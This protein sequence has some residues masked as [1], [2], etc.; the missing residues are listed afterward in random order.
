MGR[1][2]RL[3][4]VSG[5]TWWV[6]AHQARISSKRS[7]SLPVEADGAALVVEGLAELARTCRFQELEW[8]GAGCERAETLGLLRW[9]VRI[10]HVRNKIHHQTLQLQVRGEILLTRLNVEIWAELPDRRSIL[11]VLGDAHFAHRELV[12]D[13]VVSTK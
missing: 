9:R 4:C 6:V 3:E 8:L 13:D 10:L 5:E 12:S 11:E 7:D 1:S 2:N